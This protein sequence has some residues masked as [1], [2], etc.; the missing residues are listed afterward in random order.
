MNIVQSSY[1]YLLS[2]FKG[3]NSSAMCGWKTAAVWDG[4]NRISG[5]GG[6]LNVDLWSRPVAVHNSSANRY[7]WPDDVVIGYGN[8]STV[9]TAADAAFL[10]AIKTGGPSPMNASDAAAALEVAHATH[11]SASNNGA[12]ITLNSQ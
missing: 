6:C 9:V 10:N 2:C 1:E 12:L 5:T 7:F 8:Y 11:Q 3:R 4:L